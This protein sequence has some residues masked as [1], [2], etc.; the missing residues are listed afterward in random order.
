[1]QD[2][3]TILSWISHR[4]AGLGS[5][6]PELQGFGR[7]RGLHAGGGRLSLDAS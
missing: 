6:C 3:A 7:A 1:M 4:F 2:F 5:Y